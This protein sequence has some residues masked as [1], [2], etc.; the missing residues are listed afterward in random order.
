MQ[1]ERERDDVEQMRVDA[2]APPGGAQ[3]PD[4]GRQTERQPVAVVAEERDERRVNQQRQRHVRVD[5]VRVAHRVRA[6]VHVVGRT[7]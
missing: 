4:R 1:H 2:E 6:A 7:V 5:G 3:Q